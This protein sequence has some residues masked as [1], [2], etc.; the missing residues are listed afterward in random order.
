M[1][2][3]KKIKPIHYITFVLLLLFVLFG[4]SII[5]NILNYFYK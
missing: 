5:D 3:E 4:E 1:K 2:K